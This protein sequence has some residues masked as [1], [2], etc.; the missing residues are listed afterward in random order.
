MHMDRFIAGRLQSLFLYHQFFNTMVAHNRIIFVLVQRYT[1]FFYR[2]NVGGLLCILQTPL[3][4]R[5]FHTSR[6]STIS[7]Q[8][9]SRNHINLL[10]RNAILSTN[11][12]NILVPHLCSLLLHLSMQDRTF[13]NHMIKGF[14]ILIGGSRICTFSHVV[15]L[16]SA[17]LAYNLSPTSTK[18]STSSSASKVSMTC[19]SLGILRS[20]SIILLVTLHRI[21]I[22]SSFHHQFISSGI[23]FIMS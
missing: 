2:S 11:Q 15:A 6:L 7:H 3:Y 23:I 5:L 19:S 4:S 18:S 1:F 9:T 13:L 20:A 17:V 21:H 8:P 12:L 14:T 10:L 22:L 16:L